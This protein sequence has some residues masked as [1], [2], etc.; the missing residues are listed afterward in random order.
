M[1]LF[2]QRPQNSQIRVDTFGD[3]VTFAEPAAAKFMTKLGKLYCGQVQSQTTEGRVAAGW[4]AQNTSVVPPVLI[5]Q[6]LVMCTLNRGVFMTF[7]MWCFGV[8][9]RPLSTRGRRLERCQGRSR[10][11]MS[12]DRKNALMV[13]HL[14]DCNGLCF[15][16][17]RCSLWMLCWQRSLCLRNFRHVASVLS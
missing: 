13:V 9:S 3:D 10:E 2:E 12:L 11:K 8:L 5:H 1:I 17:S 14:F 15:L 6:P 16:L 4:G 7:C